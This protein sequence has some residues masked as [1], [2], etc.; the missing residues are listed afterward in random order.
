MARGTDCKAHRHDAPT[1]Q[2]RHHIQP[3]SRG[4]GNEPANLV[5]LCAN[6][7]GDVHYFL[8]LVEKHG[9]PERVPWSLAKHYGPAIRAYAVHGWLKYADDFHAGRLDMHRFLWLSSGDPVPGR[10]DTVPPF[11][12]AASLGTV[13]TWLA[14]AQIRRRNEP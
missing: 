10:A 11:H 4:G 7:H 9:A 5:I 14:V 13:D 12:L 2:E 3:L 8:D 6:A 1:A